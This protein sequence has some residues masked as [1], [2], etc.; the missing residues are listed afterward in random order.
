MTDE[1][2][3]EILKTLETLKQNNYISLSDKHHRMFEEAKNYALEQMLENKK[4]EPIQNLM[5][6]T[7]TA[8]Q[9]QIEQNRK[10]EADGFNLEE[11]LNKLSKEHNLHPIETTTSKIVDREHSPF[12]W[13]KDNIIDA[14]D[15]LKYTQNIL[16]TLRKKNEFLDTALKDKNITINILDDKS[17]DGKFKD[18]EYTKSNG[19]NVIININKGC[20]DENNKNIL[21]MLIAHEFGHFID[22][23][24][25]PLGYT[26][27]LK[28]K[29]EFFA[30][31][32]GAKMATNA[33]YENS[34]TA[35]KNHLATRDDPLLK[36]RANLLK[37]RY[38]E[39]KVEQN[40]KNYADTIANLRGTKTTNP[41]FKAKQ[42]NIDSNHIKLSK[43]N[44]S[45]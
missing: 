3:D 30:D 7:R 5:S 2:F 31:S 12:I 4:P 40:N 28:D 11:H 29:E 18:D 43:D 27:G 1:K 41:S 10:I 45:R 32:I 33:G 25:R 34:I 9:K 22:V 6:C 26:G 44:F 37:E 8:S 17:I 21:P 19:K 24:S 42:T 35:F 14:P 39:P 16:D 13:M 38:P 36:S 23:S 15:E 20:F